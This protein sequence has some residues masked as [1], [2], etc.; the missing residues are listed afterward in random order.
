MGTGDGGKWVGVQRQD[1]E[2]RVEEGDWMKVPGVSFTHLA[3]QK[4][5]DSEFKGSRPEPMW[6]Q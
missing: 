4:V 6:E 5:H 1:M 2:L 3:D